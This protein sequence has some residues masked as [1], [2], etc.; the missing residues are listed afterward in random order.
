MKYLLL[1]YLFNGP[2][3]IVLQSEFLSMRE[4]QDAKTILM[5]DKPDG[6]IARGYCFPSS[7]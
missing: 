3:G 5:A 6:M 2:G 4:C 1:F 7:R